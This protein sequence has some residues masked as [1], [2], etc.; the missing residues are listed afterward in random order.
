MQTD[1]LVASLGDEHPSRAV[2][3][4]A[5]LEGLAVA[6]ALPDRA[7]QRL[8]VTARRIAWLERHAGHQILVPR[9]GQ[10]IHVGAESEMP[11]RDS[12]RCERRPTADDQSAV[13]GIDH[14]EGPR[15]VC[16]DFDGLIA[17][18]EEPRLRVVPGAGED[19]VAEKE[20][21]PLLGR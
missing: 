13:I 19:R 8:L 14:R 16:Q 17:D 2:P 9:V 3:N 4:L 18:A 15:T 11:G 10:D 1:A 20:A 21:D 5:N 7:K 6:V 12:K